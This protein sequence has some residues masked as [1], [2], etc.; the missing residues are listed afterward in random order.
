MSKKIVLRNVRLSFEHVF[1]PASF[2]DGQD[3]KYSAD[4]IV[5]KNHP[6]L[7]ALKRALFEAGQETFPND[8]TKAGAWPRGFSCSLKDADVETDNSGTV[9]A[10]K[11]D[12]YKN[13]YILK[14][15]SNK[16]PVVINR[17]KAA[18][19]E[20]DGL[21]YSGCWV[22]VS[23][24][25]AGYTYGKMTKGVKAYLNGVQFVKDDEPFGSNAMND[26]DALDG[27]DDDFLA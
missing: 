25:I 10:E 6:D 22:N 14:A 3:P 1:K 5:P 13:S 4:L 24:G 11:Y 18:V 8:F 2:D 9:L 17:A 23:L 15:N 21:I 19:T 12:S 7:P 20:E 26:F 16:R 27:D